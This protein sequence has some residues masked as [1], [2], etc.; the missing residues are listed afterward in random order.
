[1]KLKGRQISE[2]YEK[3]KKWIIYGSIG[4]LVIISYF[5]GVFGV[6]SSKLFVTVAA[7]ILIL[8]FETTISLS[9][10]LKIKPKKRF[11]SISTALPEIEKIVSQDREITSVKI[12]A[13]TG[14]TTLSSILPLIISKSN[15]KKIE[16]SMGVLDPSI[17]S[18][19]TPS[20]WTSEIKVSLQRLKTQFTDPRVK[21][22]FFLFE[23]LTPP[24]GL[25]INNK[26]LF[27][28][29]FDWIMSG[30]KFELSGAQLPH[31]YYN[32][33]DLEFDYYF[34]LFESWFNRSP[35]REID[36]MFVFDFDGTLVD[37]YACLPD[38]YKFI[39]SFIDL[40]HDKINE[41]INKMIE[42]EDRQDALGNYN[43]HEW[44]PNVFRHFNINLSEDKLIQLIVIYWRER[45]DK[46]KV[47]GDCKDTLCWFRKKGI[48][49]IV[50]TGDGKYGNKK[51]RIRQSGLEKLFDDIIIVGEDVQTESQAIMSLKNEYNIDD[52]KITVFDDKPSP[53]NELSNNMKNVKTV[54][55]EFE[56]ILK[57]AWL[58]KCNFT[59]RFN[60]IDEFKISP[61]ND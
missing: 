18:E 24:H 20:H 6:W 9:E 36:R 15:A 46:S 2:I 42:N 45:A 33:N 61:I 17:L 56:S 13:V 11:S 32:T 7:V 19:Y 27:L 55:I 50:C 22:N 14:G 37:S 38:V 41:F 26:H 10:S 40:P 25:L 57:S 43:R 16:I 31:N 60:T 3:V 59:Y 34:N 30:E 35:H 39:A 52:A 5:G 28:G 21:I 48:L 29:F 8:L 23:T 53:L 58:E 1:M 51:E 44:W 12:I 54:K 47:I 4:F 49:A